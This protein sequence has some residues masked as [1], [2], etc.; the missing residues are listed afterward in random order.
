MTS[1]WEEKRLED[2]AKAKELAKDRNWRDYWG[3]RRRLFREILVL[4]GEFFPEQEEV[5]REHSYLYNS[6]L[7]RIGY[8]MA[9]E[10]ATKQAVEAKGMEGAEAVEWDAENG[11]LI[12]PG[13]DP[14]V[15]WIEVSTGSP[16]AYGPVTYLSKGPSLPD[17]GKKSP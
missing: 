10:A 13:K 12:V 9:R 16:M 8:Q 7:Q 17:V 15:Q 11:M 5:R 2:Q 4:L 14:T 6:V 3:V 1:P